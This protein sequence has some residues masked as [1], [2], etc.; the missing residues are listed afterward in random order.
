MRGLRQ[1]AFLLA[2]VFLCVLAVRADAASVTL[3]EGYFYDANR[4]RTILYKLYAPEPLESQSPVVIFSHGLG[5]STAS[6]PYLGEALAAHGYI[7]FFIQ[8]PGSD[9]E[10]WKGKTDPEEINQALRHASRHPRVAMDRFKDLPVVLEELEAM[11]QQRGNPLYRMMDLGRIGMAGHSYGGRSVMAAAGEETDLEGYSF[12]EPRI[13]AAVVL[14]PNVPDRYLGA[15]DADLTAVYKDVT[16]P[17]FHIT[18]TKDDH[19]FSAGGF[20]PVTRTMPFRNIAA[21]GQYLL[22]LGGADH[23]SFGGS[24]VRGMKTSDVPYQKLVAEAVVLFFDAKL[25]GNVQAEQELT[26]GFPRKLSGDDVFEYK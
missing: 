12:H 26:I 3:S 23:Y 7:A 6:A 18:G 2:F 19:P 11:N 4:D 1:A 9:I 13:K 10:I 8:H 24:I 20:D 16:I 5:G 21:P 14:S 22:V 17:V 25:K 15:P